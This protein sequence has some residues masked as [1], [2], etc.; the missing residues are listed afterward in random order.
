MV[1]VCGALGREQIF[2]LLL[3]SNYSGKKLNEEAREEREKVCVWCVYV[4]VVCV[5]V[6]VSFSLLGSY[7]KFV[8]DFIFVFLCFFKES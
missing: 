3:V 5:S 7:A 6:C 2:F 1:D 4:C 8:P